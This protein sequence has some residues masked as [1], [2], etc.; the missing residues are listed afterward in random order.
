MLESL[1]QGV[2]T[3]HE[4]NLDGAFP[5]RVPYRPRDV[6]EAL[7]ETPLFDAERGQWNHQMFKKP[8]LEVD[9]T[10]RY[11]RAQL[12]GVLAEAQF[13]PEGARELY[14]ELK[15]TPLYDPARG[16][17]NLGMS[18]EQRL[19]SNTRYASYQLLGVLAEAQFDRE[20][21]RVLHEELKTTPLYDS[22]RGQWNYLMSEEQI[23]R[24]T[25]R[26]ADVQ[27]LGVVA[28]AQCNR[29]GAWA[30]YERLKETPLYD[31]AR[32]QWNGAMS[33]V[34]RLKD[35]ERDSYAQL[36]GVL[37]EAQ[38]DPEGARARYEELKATPLYDPSAGWWNGCMSEG[39]VLQSTHWVAAIQLLG[40]LVEARLLST[41]RRPL[42]GAVP[43]MPITEEW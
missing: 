34:Q 21:A 5:E 40:V 27:L 42:A 14:A 4:L 12:F 31:P 26:D 3:I 15:T 24:N 25:Q 41:L 33:G 9:G 11:A 2:A 10:A 35:T 30:L 8:I 32:R 18:E 6:Y 7:K 13:N 23:V 17:W 19:I 20:A 28:E 29:E 39:Q 1:C 38:F 36:L 43:P 16:Q 22:K 37:A